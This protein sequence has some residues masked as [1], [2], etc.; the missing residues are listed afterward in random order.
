LPRQTEHSEEPGSLPAPELNPLLNPVLGQN[1]G[2]WA[3][4]YF[5]SPPEK[6]EQAVLELVRELEG[7]N[8]IPDGRFATTAHPQPE[9]AS[10]PILKNDLQN[11][12]DPRIVPCH[13]C[14]RDL[15]AAQRYCGM[16]G[17]PRRH[18]EAVADMH[19][20]DLVIEDQQIEDQQI[21]DA[22]QSARLGDRKSQYS[23][24]GPDVYEPRSTTNEL[25]LF[26]S[27]RDGDYRDNDRDNDDIFSYAPPSRPYRV[28]VVLALAIV[29]F[30]LAYM[31]WRSAQAT[32][33]SSHVESQAPPAATEPDASTPAQPDSSRTHSGDAE[34]TKTNSPDTEKT[35]VPEHAP[36]ANQ[37]SPAPPSPVQATEQAGAKTSEAKVSAAA[38]R[39]IAAH[40][41]PAPQNPPAESLTGNGAEELGIAQRYLNGTD[42]ERRN[43]AEGA[44]WLWKAMAKHNTRSMLLLA[45]LYLKG[46]GVSKNCDQAHVLLDSAA[47]GGVKEAG[48][49]LRH[50]QAF[51]CQ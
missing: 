27:G 20:A 33:Q 42:G 2:R 16:C 36:T 22:S 11:A 44:K 29:I 12:I 50:L 25:S 18:G 5:T 38:P 39:P 1:M 34:K 10:E 31:A 32:S 13:A 21:E 49:R 51:G 47:R 45:D 14:G 23:S 9:P 4:V 48:E 41:T 8:P 26:Q 24:R 30:A 35:G 43:S 46:D 17:A 19:V 15:P 6:R 40:T 7:K 3:E 28:Y 37:Q